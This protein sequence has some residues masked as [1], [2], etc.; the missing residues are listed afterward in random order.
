MGQR[1]GAHGLVEQ[2]AGDEVVVAMGQKVSAQL[3]VLGNAPAQTDARQRP[4]LAHGAGGDA[5]VVKVD[6][7]LGVLV[8]LVQVAVHLVAVQPRV[9][10]ARHLHDGPQRLAVEQGTRGVVGIVDADDL[11]LRRTQGVQGLHVHVV[12][13]LLF[14]MQHVHRS[15]AHLGD[16]VELLVGGHDRHHVVAR[17]HQRR[18]HECVGAG[19]PVGGDDVL[20]R[21]GA[22]ELG[23]ARKQVGATL[24]VAVGEAA[25]REGVQKRLL[26]AAGQLEELVEGQRVHARLGDVV[27]ALRLPEVHPLLDFE[28]L[29]LH[30]GSPS[31]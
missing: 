16:G 29:D 21:H 20:G 5:L 8:G 4:H 18:E 2:A 10:L 26:V 7:R 28:I 27:G 13:V 3:F 30:G 23:D 6:D 19:G 12:A 22:V 25:R 11:R 31:R 17:V 15:A 9:V 1:V 24:D 14:Q